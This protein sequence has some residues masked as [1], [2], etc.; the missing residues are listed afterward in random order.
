M[1]ASTSA[2]TYELIYWP[3]APGRGEHVRLALEE[4]G[5][6]YS[7]TSRLENSMEIV[8]AQMGE[9]NLGDKTNPPPFAPPI[10]KHGDVVI[11]QTPNILMYLGPKLGLSASGTE[12]DVYWINALAL[13]VLDGLSNEVHDC[14][15]PIAKEL[16]Y[17]DQKEESIRRSKEWV[18]HRL[19]KHLG[20]FEKVLTGEASG[21][22]P[23]LYKGVLTYADLVL[24]H[25]LD[26]TMFQF[27]KACE[28]AKKSGK[29]EKVF[30]LYDAVKARPN[31]TAYLASDRRWA[32]SPL[33]IYRYYEE[34]DVVAE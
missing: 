20:Y 27:P 10:L 30:H 32:Y 24:F 28:L 12:N 14:H 13:T 1:S 23:W 33:G 6:S 17:E 16:Y 34:L 8:A 18:K 2:T 5:A 11:S 7:D 21:D 15:H 26:G 9:A 22:G 4:A 29:F 25:C 31:I 3:G 19:P